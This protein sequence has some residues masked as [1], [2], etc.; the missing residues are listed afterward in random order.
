MPI[1]RVSAKLHPDDSR[2]VEVILKR[3]K[4][5][6]TYDW[7]KKVKLETMPEE[8]EIHVHMKQAFESLARIHQVC[9]N[10]GDTR[11][12]YGAALEIYK[13]K[14]D[15]KDKTGEF[16]IVVFEGSDTTTPKSISR[17]PVHVAEQLLKML[18]ES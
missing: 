15:N 8:F 10:I 7:P 4:L 17:I 2:T 3:D 5:L 18:V 6:E 12:V 11:K 13:I 9:L 16:S 1:S 14:V